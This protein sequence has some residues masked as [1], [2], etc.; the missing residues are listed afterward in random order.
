MSDARKLKSLE[1]GWT[2]CVQRAAE[3]AAA[4]LDARCLDAAGY[5]GKKF[6]TPGSRRKAVTWAIE[7]KDYIAPGKPQQSGFVESFNGRFRDECLNEHLFG[8]LPA[9][10]RII[11]AWRSG[12]NTARPRTS[13]NGLTPAAFA[14]RPALDK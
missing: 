3:E 2:H 4:G 14:N 9:A 5:A 12:D 8:T 13:L 6:L 10:R 11:E 1:E 7:E